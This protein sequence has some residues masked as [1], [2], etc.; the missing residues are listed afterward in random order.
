METVEYMGKTFS[1][2]EDGFIDD[3]ITIVLS[4]NSG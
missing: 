4:G 3:L 2:D 1:V